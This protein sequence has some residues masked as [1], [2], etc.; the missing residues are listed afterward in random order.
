MHVM[1]KSEQKEGVEEEGTD[2]DRYRGRVE[3]KRE[4]KSHRK[5]GG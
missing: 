1:Y 5:G 2:R 3:G 4:R